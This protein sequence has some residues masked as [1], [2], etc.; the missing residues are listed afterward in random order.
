MPGPQ[1]FHVQTY[2]RKPNEKGQSVEQVLAKAGRA[3]KFSQH[4]AARQAAGLH[5]LARYNGRMYRVLAR[6]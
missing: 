3:P 6:D 2:S 4:V 5:E 1:F